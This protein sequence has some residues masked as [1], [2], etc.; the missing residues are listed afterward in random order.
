MFVDFP[1]ILR[2]IITMN[3]QNRFYN[4]S[5]NSAAFCALYSECLYITPLPFYATKIFKTFLISRI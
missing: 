2:V 5:T 3:R 4:R 1:I